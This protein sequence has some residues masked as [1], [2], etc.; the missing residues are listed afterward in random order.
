MPGTVTAWQHY[1]CR[2]AFREYVQEQHALNKE[3]RHPI[4]GSRQHRQKSYARWQ[5]SLGAAP[6]LAA[7][8]AF[9]SLQ[10][11]RYRRRHWV[12]LHAAPQGDTRDDLVKARS[13]YV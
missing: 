1:P 9:Q 6:A 3:L 8:R 7:T 4:L 10:L 13:T 12:Q 11:A 2:K 5:C